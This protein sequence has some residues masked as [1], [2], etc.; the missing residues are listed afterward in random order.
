MYN[1]WCDLLRTGQ[2]GNSGST[3]CKNDRCIDRPKYPYWL[4]LPR[5]SFSMATARQQASQWN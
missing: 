1:L 5:S 2:P 3:P 4:R